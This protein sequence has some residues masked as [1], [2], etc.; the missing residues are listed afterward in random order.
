MGDKIKAIL[1]TAVYAPSGDN[2][3]PWYFVVE[4]QNLKIYNRPEKDKTLYN[5]KQH[6]S[7]VAHG[8]LIENISISSGWFNLKPIIKLLPDP[9]NENLIASIDFVENGLSEEKDNLYNFIKKRATNRKFY[10]DT[11][12][13][14]NH[15]KALLEFNQNTEGHA[16][17]KLVTDKTTINLLAKTLSTADR[18]IFENKSIHDFLFSHIRW[19][20][21]E[22]KQKKSGLYIKT[23]ELNPA[24]T[25]AFKIFKSWSRMKIF[26]A[27]G[28]PKQAVKSN[29]KLY[30]KVS[31]IGCILAPSNTSLDYLNAGRLMQKIWLKATEL[32]LRMQ[33]LTAIP[34]LIQKIFDENYDSLET[35]QIDLIKK[36]NT[37]IKNI[38]DF[39]DKTAV[40]LFRLGEGPEPSAHSSRQQPQIIWK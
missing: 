23:M 2:I 4:N 32:N 25:L 14:P 38:F 31:A 22:E 33:P 6:G 21:E 35:Y 27:L 12:L 30:S 39:G 37:T 17:L 40:M 9:N 11:R 34:F 36:A 10:N 18:L 3:Q 28:I 29:I 13:D 15:E 26:N 5:Y 24:Q 16:Q 1:E 20:E 8:A 7:M 19:T